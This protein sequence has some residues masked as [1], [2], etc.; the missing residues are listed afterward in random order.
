M[1]KEEDKG[2]CNDCPFK[3]ADED[4]RCHRF[5]PHPVVKGVSFEWKFPQVKAGYWCGEHPKRKAA[6]EID[7]DLA[8]AAAEAIR[9]ALEQQGGKESKGKGRKNKKEEGK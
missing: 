1:G 8:K 6:M 4:F 9:L 5:P 3:T 2:F 7:N